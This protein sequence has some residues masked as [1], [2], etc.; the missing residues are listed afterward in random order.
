LARSREVIFAEKT[1]HSYYDPMRCIRTETHKLI[2]N[3]ET[4][5]L[6]E[7]PGDIQR[8]PIF[9]AHVELYSADRPSTVELYDLREDPLEQRNLAGAAA[10]KGIERELDERLWKWM[11]DTDDPLLAG[12]VASPRYRRAMG[13]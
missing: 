7:V 2:R 1:F 12:P 13:R 5:F 9:R 10:F 6:V 4:G 3:F 8:G 11:R